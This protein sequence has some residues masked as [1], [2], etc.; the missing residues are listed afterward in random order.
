MSTLK[1]YYNEIWDGVTL[2][3]RLYVYKHYIL[4]SVLNE[5]K[6]FLK[7]IEGQL[8]KLIIILLYVPGKI[9]TK[10]TFKINYDKNE[11]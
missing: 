8:N 1:K 10:K 5:R 2:K 6:D 9:K 4:F 11:F 3:Q 7:N